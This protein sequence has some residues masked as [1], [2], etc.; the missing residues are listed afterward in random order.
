M[1]AKKL[2]S[3]NWRA[4]ASKTIDGQR[5]VKSFTAD[6]KAEAEFFASQWVTK[7]KEKVN[8]PTV[9]VAID[10]FLDN[11][12]AIFSPS[13]YKNYIPLANAIKERYGRLLASDITSEKLQ[14]YVNELSVTRSPKTVRNYYTFFTAVLKTTMPDRAYRV[15]LP[16]KLPVEYN[17]PCEDAVKRLL[18]ESVG[19]LH[20]AILLGAVGGFRRG[21]I[22]AI[23]QEDVLRDVNMIYIHADMVK[24]E[25]NEWIY[26]PTPKTSASVRRVELPPQIIEQIPKEPGFIIKKDPDWIS[27]NFGRYSRKKGV[28]CRFHDLRHYCASYLHSIGVPDQYIIERLGHESDTTLKDVYRNILPDKADMFAK[29]ANEAFSLSLLDNQSQDTSQAT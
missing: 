27:R 4:R 3:G 9:A 7:R 23:K 8:S 11:R 12:K 17:V 1:R 28:N 25:R 16:K 19:D 18:D 10:T 5:V 2:P 14:A 13:T 24:N 26:K 22:C 20:L 29:K 15:N 21:E 6:T